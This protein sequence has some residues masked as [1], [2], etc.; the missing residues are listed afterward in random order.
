MRSA[1]LTGS[2]DRLEPASTGSIAFARPKSSTFTVPPSRTLMF[3]GLRSRW[4]MP[5]SCAASSASAICRAIADR[6]VE[7]NRPARDPLREILALDELHHERARSVRLEA[8]DLRDV[9][10]VQRGED[11]AS[12]SK[13]AS[14]SASA[15]NGSGRTLIATS[16]CSF[17]SLARYTS[18]MPPAPMAPTISYGPRRVPDDSGKGGRIIGCRFGYCR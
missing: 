12:R 1:G 5:R 3:A 10:M 13:R 15:A 8:V 16:R 9:R 17:V 7:R 18:P 6:F 11:C 4:T 14:R 2:P